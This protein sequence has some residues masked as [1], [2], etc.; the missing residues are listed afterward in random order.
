MGRVDADHQQL[1]VFELGLQVG[2]EVAPV[3]RIG[4]KNPFPHAIERNVMITR[5]ADGRDAEILFQAVDE[6]TGVAKLSWFGAD[7][8]VARDDDQVRASFAR[9]LDDAAGDVSTV[10]GAEV[11]IGYMKYL[12]QGMNVGALGRVMC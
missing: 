10:G 9:Q 6:S 4:C 12:S 8:Q 2:R 5:Y 11:N 7:R 3:R 1:V